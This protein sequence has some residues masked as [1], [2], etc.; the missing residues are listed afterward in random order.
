M[1]ERTTKQKGGGWRAKATHNWKENHSSQYFVKKKEKG[2]Y[3]VKKDNTKHRPVE[4]SCSVSKQKGA[5]EQKISV[6]TAQEH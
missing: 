3:L 6:T 2:Q 1:V 4:D 5:R